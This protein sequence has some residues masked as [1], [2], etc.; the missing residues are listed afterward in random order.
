MT[1]EGGAAVV[2]GAASGIGYGLCEGAAQRG[3]AVVLADI[4][5]QSLEAAERRLRESG[6]R[7]LSVRTDVSRAEDLENL[8]NRAFETFGSVGLLC[9][10][11]GVQV[12]VTKPIW[13]YSHQDWE[14]LIGVNLW[15][16][17]HGLQAF[18]PRLMDQ[19]NASHVLNTASSAGMLISP[20]LGV[21]KATKHAVVSLS[22][23]LYHDLRVAQS[24]VGVS[25]FCPDVVKTGL[26]DAARNRPEELGEELKRTPEEQAAEDTLRGSK[27]LTPS[28]A[29]EIA[30]SSI[31][32][33]RFYIFTEDGPI[34]FTRQR[35]EGIEAGVPIAATGLREDLGLSGP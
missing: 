20:G 14:W 13:R 31:E 24:Q 2:T 5:E 10:N 8:A 16:V 30:L 32:A 35:L 7:T 1:I 22:E 29:G 21:Y 17:V 19:A 28:E 25:V 33:G 26:R 3:L 34:E 6:A 27:G 23:T 15:G 4:E 18:L 12:S 11:A 9:N